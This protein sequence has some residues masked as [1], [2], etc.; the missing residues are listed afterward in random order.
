MNFIF[1]LHV[2]FDHSLCEEAVAEPSSSHK[3]GNIAYDVER[4]IK[5]DV[6]LPSVLPSSPGGGVLHQFF[7]RDYGSVL[8][9]WC[10]GAGMR[11]RERAILCMHMWGMWKL[12]L[13]VSFHVC[14]TWSI[15]WHCVHTYSLFPFSS[16]FLLWTAV[17]GSQIHF[18]LPNYKFHHNFKLV[19]FTW[20]KDFFHTDF[21]TTK[22]LHNKPINVDSFCCWIL[23]ASIVKSGYDNMD[24]RG[25]DNNSS[26]KR[27]TEACCSGSTG[28]CSSLGSY[29]GA[30]WGQH[31]WYPIL[32]LLFKSSSD[33]VF[34]KVIFLCFQTEELL[35]ELNNHLALKYVL[36]TV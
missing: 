30:W 24:S 34:M 10:Q 1:Q 31:W 36:K 9:L 2:W 3:A 21:F 4:E 29:H 5:E 6:S 25:K 11:Q 14:K 28:C 26:Y 32:L 33:E 23:A 35:E 18:Q 12:Q 16:F 27:G 17:V 15:Y 22:S 13:Q 19:Q 7:I 20:K 8:G